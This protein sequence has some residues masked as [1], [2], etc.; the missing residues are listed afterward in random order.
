MRKSDKV[1][2]TGGLCE[3]VYQYTPGRQPLERIAFRSMR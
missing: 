3:V 2:G 1:Y